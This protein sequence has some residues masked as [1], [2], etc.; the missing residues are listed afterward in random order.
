MQL[1]TDL[2]E[3]LVD[4]L[5]DFLDAFAGD[6]DPE[7]LTNFIVEQLE[8]YADDVGLDDIIGQLEQSGPTEFTFTEFLET[9][10]Q[11]NDELAQTGEELISLLE[12]AYAIEWDEDISFDGLEEEEEEDEELDF[13]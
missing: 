6:A 11:S 2:R 7:V 13:L 3:A 8:L 12:R 5:D 1:P 4:S 10:L 9:E